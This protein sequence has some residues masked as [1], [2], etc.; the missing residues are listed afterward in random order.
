LASA[1]VNEA[2]ASPA[3]VTAV[4]DRV[5]SRER[6]PVYVPPPVCVRVDDDDVVGVARV[7]I[8]AIGHPAHLVRGG[9]SPLL[10]PSWRRYP[11]TAE[12]VCARM[13]R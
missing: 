4:S 9:P 7:D 2:V 13:L 3:S 6:L 12:A 8:A 11:L 1:P 5:P 10:R